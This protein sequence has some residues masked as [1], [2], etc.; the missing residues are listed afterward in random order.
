MVEHKKSEG[1]K[2]EKGGSPG[3]P[4]KKEIPKPDWRKESEPQPQGPPPQP[5]PTNLS[6]IALHMPIEHPLGGTA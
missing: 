6:A 2:P 5:K 3:E 1:Q 4:E